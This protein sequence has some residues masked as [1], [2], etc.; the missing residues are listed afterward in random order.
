MSRDNIGNLIILI[1]LLLFIAFV[2]PATWRE[3]ADANN[4]SAE[5]IF[6]EMHGVKP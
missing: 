3:Y 4:W 6:F 5:R 1:G 2:F